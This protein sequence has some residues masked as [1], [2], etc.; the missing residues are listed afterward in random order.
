MKKTTPTKKR[1]TTKKAAP[2]QPFAVF[3]TSADLKSALLIVSLF[4]NFFVFCLWL[5]LQVTSQYDE[6]LVD[7]L[8]HR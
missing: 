4:I 7:F 3:Q 6:A 8:I 1:T 2:H 5:T